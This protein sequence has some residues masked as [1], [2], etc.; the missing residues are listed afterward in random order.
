MNLLG[1]RRT[2]PDS[3]SYKL[4]G[5][6]IDLSV[7]QREVT[8]PEYSLFAGKARESRASSALRPTLQGMCLTEAAEVGRTWSLGALAPAACRPFLLS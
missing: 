4:L 1:H 5:L 8:S 6:F 2:T 3:L 7:H